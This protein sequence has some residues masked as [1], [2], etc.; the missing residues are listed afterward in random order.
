MKAQEPGLL[1]YCREA[2]L[3][4]HFYSAKE[5][6]ALRGDF[7][8]SEFVKSVTGVDNVCERAARMEGTQLVVKKTACCGVTV[9][10]AAEYWEV[11]FG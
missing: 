2:G 5:L 7:T 11:R 4:V 9:A 8:P 10:L 1:E 3:P 6:N